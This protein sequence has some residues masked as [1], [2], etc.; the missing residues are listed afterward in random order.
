MTLLKKFDLHT[1]RKRNEFLSMRSGSAQHSTSFVLQMRERKN[2]LLS[3]S[4]PDDAIRVGYTVTKKIGN[5]VE[6]NRIRRRMREAAR[7]A[8]PGTGRPSHDYVMIGKRAALNSN[9]E[10][11]VAELGSSLKRVHRHGTKSGIQNGK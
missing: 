7:L 8:L 10:T 4:N 11:L 6:R 5:A 3:G 9:F 1:L 2:H